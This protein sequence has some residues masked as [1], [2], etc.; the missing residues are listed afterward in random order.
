MRRIIR[1]AHAALPVAACAAALLPAAPAAAA[2]GRAYG[3]AGL[4]AGVDSSGVAATIAPLRVPG[5]AG[6]HVAAWVGLGG[7]T[8]APDGTA[9]WLQIGLSGFA[10]G[11]S[12]L[13]V[14][15]ALPGAQPSYTEL[16]SG[17]RVGEFHRVAV[18]EI[19]H[20]PGWW[21]VWLDGT[22]AGAPVEL[23]GSHGRWR[24]MAMAES[25]NGGSGVCNDFRYAFRDVRVATAPGGSWRLLRRAQPLVDAG[26]RLVRTGATGFVAGS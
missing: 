11:R 12:S 3:Y 22:P 6:G 25:W 5:V 9:E 10:G 18:L 23:P 26:Y 16:L 13:Y 15:V 7:P 8:A 2:C 21:R 24:P 19:A 17:V 1:A 14:E 4:L 20:R